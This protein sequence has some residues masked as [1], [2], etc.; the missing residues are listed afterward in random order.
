MELFVFAP[1]LVLLLPYFRIDQY[2]SPENQKKFATIMLAIMYILLCGL[3]DAGGQD[4]LEYKRIYEEN[5]GTQFV[6]LKGKEPLYL[7]LRIVGKSFNLNY[8]SMFLFYA[9]ITAFFISRACLNFFDS[10]RNIQLFSAAFLFI[11]FPTAFTVMRQT[12]AMA[13]VFYIY[14]KKTISWKSRILLWTFAILSHYGFI[15]LL[16]IEILGCVRQY[17][18]NRTLRW[19]VPMICWGVGSLGIVAWLINI[20]V[21]Y[22]GMYSYMSTAAENSIKSGSGIVKITI[23]IIY[24]LVT[25]LSIKKSKVNEKNKEKD[26]RENKIVWGEFFYISIFLFTQNIWGASRI[27]F[28]YLLFAPMLVIQLL[29]VINFNKKTRKLVKNICI[30]TLYVLYLIYVKNNIVSDAF[31]WSFSFI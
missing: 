13:I 3:K 11:A 27:A 8:K 19:S 23:V 14:S 7:I 5:Y 26:L 15:L 22:T 10:A 20:V 21:T 6:F 1:L 25:F 4:D 12:V 29:E 16:P 17:Q 18:I 24:L 31:S 9:V 30:W 28:Y 2:Y